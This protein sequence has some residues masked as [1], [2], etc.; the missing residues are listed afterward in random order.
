MKRL[1]VLTVLSILSLAPF[2]R[3]ELPDTLKDH[4]RVVENSINGA[5][6]VTIGGKR[7]VPY[8]QF[9]E[10]HVSADPEDSSKTIS[11]TEIHCMPVQSD[12]LTDIARMHLSMSANE[13]SKYRLSRSRESIPVFKDLRR[14]S[15]SAG[16]GSLVDCVLTSSDGDKV[17]CNNDFILGKK[18]LHEIGKYCLNY[19]YYVLK[20]PEGDGVTSIFRLYL[21]EVDEKGNYYPPFSPEAILALGRVYF[22]S[23]QKYVIEN[24]A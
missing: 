16:S 19:D 9:L 21:I 20:S 2:V 8:W 7:Y 4:P 3:A 5:R 11:D 18:T 13:P 14:R 24:Q 10:K 22:Q 6:F 17:T 23:L 15:W 12:E 1:K